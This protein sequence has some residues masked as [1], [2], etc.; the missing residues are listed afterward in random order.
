[1]F[2]SG[3]TPTPS[4]NPP[5]R[6]V[7]SM[8]P[9]HLQSTLYPTPKNLTQ[10]QVKGSPNRSMIALAIQIKKIPEQR[11]KRVRLT[12]GIDLAT[13]RHHA[14]IPQHIWLTQ[15]IDMFDV[16]DYP[17]QGY[18]STGIITEMHL[19]LWDCAIDYRPLYL[20]YRAIVTLGTFMVSSNIASQNT[21][22][23]LRFIAED[24]TVSLAPQVLPEIVDDKDKY[25]CRG[26]NKIS[27]L[28]A[29]ELVCVV[30]VGLFEISLRLSEKVTP[31]FPKFDLRAAINDVHIRTCADSGQA[32]AKLIGYLAE[33]G[34]LENK[35]DEAMYDDERRMSTTSSNYS[36]REDDLLA[37]RT[38]QQVVTV[39]EEQQQLVNTLLT[40]AMEDCSHVPRKYSK[41]IVVL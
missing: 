7:G 30:E 10:Q 4:S 1:M 13:L 6:L 33:N 5:L 18:K 32:L 37:V 12:A 25:K 34:D 39:P 2:H 23:T 20:P 3:L 9:S 40:D 15:L 29:S 36:T 41:Y 22:C 38:Q 28:P 31:S 17:I 8:L 11:I 27:V 26:E 21:G 19:H 14:A 16:T 35:F 24:C